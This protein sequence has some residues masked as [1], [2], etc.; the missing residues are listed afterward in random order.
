[1]HLISPQHITAYFQCSRK[2]Y[3]ML[4]NVNNYELTDYETII[5]KAKEK[6]AKTYFQKSDVQNYE[7]DILKEGFP[8][9]CGAKIRIDYFDFDCNILFRKDGNSK[10]G[11]FYY[12]LGIFIGT[13]KISKENRME[14]A[15]LSLV[16]EKIQAKFSDSAFVINKKGEQ[17]RVKI[18]PLKDEIK[19]AINEIQKFNDNPPRLFLNKHCEQCSFSE[20]CK[21]QALKEDNLTLLKRITQKQINNFE[22][23]GIFTIKQLSYIYKPRRKNRRIKNVPNNYK[24]ELQA[25][26]I[27]TEKT[28][29]QKLPFLNRNKIEIFLDIESIPEE[30][31]FYLFGVLISENDEQRYYSFWSN[32]FEDEK[33]SWL[34][35]VKL[36][37]RYPDSAIYHY[38]S[39]EP[40]AF[41][42]L[43]KRYNVS[44]DS[45]KKRF[46]NLNTFIFGKI[47][48]PVY[49]NSLKEL[50]HIL[51]MKWSNNIAS[52][53]QS[54]VWRNNWECGQKKYKPNLLKYNEEDCIAL[55]RLTNEL[56]RI[57]MSATIS[58]DLEFVE[59]P[60]K[61]ASEISNKLHNQFQ[62]VLELAHNEY[63]D[64]KIKLDILENKIKKNHKAKINKAKEFQW[65]GK[66]MSRPNKVIILEA[67]NYCYKHTE[68]K[69]TKSKIQSKRVIIDLVFGK[70]SLKK[71]VTQYIGVHGN[72]P[73]CNVSYPPLNFRQI[74][75]QLYGH[76]FRSWIV[77]QRIEI[78]LS[79]TK[80]NSILSCLINDSIGHAYGVQ[81]IKDF[82]EYY[83]DTEEKIIQNIL[84]S[85][86]IHADET[87][88]SILGE[89]QYVWIFTTDKYVTFKLSKN[90]DAI[91]TIDFLKDFKGVLISDFYA[92]YDSIDCMQQKCW[93]HLIRDLN[94]DLWSNPFDKEYE[95]FVNEVRNLIVP[96]IQSVNIH[97]YKTKYLS[98]FQVLVDKFYD[99][100]IDKK[101]YNSEL[102]ILYQKRFKRY[103]T[104]LFTFIHNDGVKW[105]NNAAENGIRHICIQ[106]KISGSFGNNQ[107][108]HYLRMVSIF[109][110]C[111]LQNKSF[112]KFLLSKEIDIDYFV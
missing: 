68:R 80:I 7:L 77:F 100:M 57:Q 109:Q 17:H 24:P 60:K 98:K 18:N 8:I 6:S 22:K 107:F 23:K 40:T 70:N 93:V 85:S 65:L 90:R 47:Y 33:T 53:L 30:N 21:N 74:S 108:P 38:G 46:V 20:L 59:K 51:G 91:T 35:L 39:F 34:D 48:F 71:T 72:C 27:R 41:E 12:E 106:R 9:V 19:K 43:S 63:N 2:A 76:N 58:N 11:N 96:I 111:K 32:T 15:F 45:L 103:R 79:F 44:I 61:I 37:L 1:M 82:S 110:T 73:I 31:F 94:N 102:S 86:F 75:R 88:V 49:S 52:G 42:V 99:K 83:K 78:Q 92:G 56:T 69:L 26:A 81:I 87:T 25:L 105:H 36:I 16:L 54:I 55:R 84:S 5:F 89:N 104:S 112:F 101:S 29:I 3:F 28:Y 64:K 4:N 62:L 97:G 10:F 95:L 50:G 66:S 67:D 14:L 13:N